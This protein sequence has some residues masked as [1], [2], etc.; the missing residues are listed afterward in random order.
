MVDYNLT[1]P[2]LH[3]CRK[4][5]HNYSLRNTKGVSPR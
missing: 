3:F 5:T 4:H 2:T 1:I